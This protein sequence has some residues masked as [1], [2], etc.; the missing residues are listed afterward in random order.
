MK[1]YS[2]VSNILILVVPAWKVSH[3]VFTQRAVDHVILQMDCCSLILNE[4]ACCLFYFEPGRSTIVQLSLE[5]SSLNFA[6][7]NLGILDHFQK[8]PRKA[9]LVRMQ[10]NWK[11]SVH[12]VS[13]MHI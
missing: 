10:L 3:Q 1:F 8:L 7:G 6:D 5:L 4:F 9:A 11:Q 12:S 2:M 13:E